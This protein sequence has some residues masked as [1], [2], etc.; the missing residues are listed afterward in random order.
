M[1]DSPTCRE[2][3]EPQQS[4]RW[5]SG[6]VLTLLL[7]AC[8]GDIGGGQG[9]PSPNSRNPNQGPGTSAGSGGV[10][11]D[12]PP[13]GPGGA[14]H[15]SGMGG[16][17]LHLLTQA[18]YRASVQSLLGPLTTPLTAP[19]DT[20]VAGFISVGAG[21]TSVTDAAATAYEASSLAATAEVFGDAA[22]WQKLVGCSPSPDL[23]DACVESYVKTFGRSAFRRDL[24]A[25]EVTQWLG[26]AKEAAMLTGS[27]AQGL[28]TMTSGLLQSPYFLYRIETNKLDPSTGRLKYDGL[29]MATRLSYLLTG[30]PPSAALLDAATSGQLDTADGVRAAAAPLLTSAAAAER[31]TAFFSEYV[32][33]YQVM[34]ADKS[35]TLF[36]DFNA[37]L[38]SSMLQSVQL[39]LKN[40]VLGPNADVRAI[41]DSDQ[42]FV[43]ANLAPIYG[44]QA[45][46]SGFAQVRLPPSS[47]RAGILGQAAVLTGQSQPD[48]TSPTRRGVFA[49]EHFLCTTPP[50]TPPGID[51]TIVV[52]TTLTTRQQLD[53]H[54]KDPQCAPCHQL[55]DPLGLALEHFDPIGK[56]RATENGKP[57]D[58][59]GELNGVAF[60]GAAQLGALLRKDPKVLSCMMRQFYKHANGRSEDDK[61]F[62]QIE[63]LV[64]M[65]STRGYVW[66]DLLTDFVASD[67]FRSAPALS[68]F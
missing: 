54:R 32:Q 44:V 22:R 66:S 61:D 27:A 67:A 46:A 51:T 57:I 6:P 11:G 3:R 10:R 50:P 9:G 58:A 2:T 21:E 53:N 39:F 48:R 28:A 19:A 35:T 60:D 62:D 30:G 14:P 33:A 13:T 41:F 42:T 40:I 26:V 20:S 65:L 25:E 12:A 36:P 34:V 7:A 5:F 63:K 31:M 47:G 52:D 29:S 17:R 68:A 43:D 49:L 18:E 16:V 23:S 55:F 45:P 15:A 64:Q 24:T 4:L 56:Y 8:T 37:A 1:K 59:T 38:K